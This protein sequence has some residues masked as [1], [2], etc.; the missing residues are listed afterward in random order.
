M[1]ELLKNIAI[2][3]KENNIPYML[4][5]SLAF[6]IYTTPRSTRDIDIVVIFSPKHVPLIK[7]TYGEQF[8]FHEETIRTEI[9]G[10]G[11]GMFNLID[12]RTGY[13][14]DFILLKDSPYELEKFKRRKTILFEGFDFQVICAEDLLVSKLQWIQQI[15][16]PIQMKDIQT[17]WQ[18]PGLD[19]KYV[20][21]WIKIL[22]LKTFDLLP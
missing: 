2:F 15:Q 6:N 11:T 10:K 4:T 17:L 21:N 5:G 19:K 13:K 9:L 12:N 8:Y 14:I 3:L 20:L 7:E 16:S 18:L 1:I 22:T